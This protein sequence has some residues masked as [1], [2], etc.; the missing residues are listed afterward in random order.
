MALDVYSTPPMS[1]EPER[2]F[3]GTGSLLSARRRQ[4]TGEG[5]EQM[6]CLRSW[7]RSGIV[8]LSQGLFNSAVAT[9]LDEDDG[10]NE[11]ASEARR[12]L[13]EDDV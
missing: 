9:T 3:S 11:A 10:F 1:D 7:D 4:M 8:T 12:F 6:T 13:V 5:V 2:V